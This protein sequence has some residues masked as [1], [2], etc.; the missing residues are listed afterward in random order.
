MWRRACRRAAMLSIADYLPVRAPRNVEILDGELGLV[1]RNRKVSN[2]LNDP[3]LR[4]RWH[5]MLAYIA[6]ERGYKPGWIAHKYKEKFDACPPWGARVR[7]EP[8]TGEVRSWV[9]SRLI[10]FARRSA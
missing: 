7:P 2:D 6:D 10:A 4:S 8:P 5:G 9:R 1:G 3:V